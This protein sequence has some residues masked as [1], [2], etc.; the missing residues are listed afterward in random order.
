M[1]SS[2]IQQLPTGLLGLLQLKNL[3][4]N[5]SVLLDDVRP[6]V[7]MLPLWL[8]T[9]ASQDP[10][11]HSSVL[12]TGGGSAR[13]FA[14]NPLLV[15]QDETWFVHRYH[16]GAS[17]DLAAADVLKN[18]CPVA[19]WNSAGPLLWNSLV[20][21]GLDCASDL[22]SSAQPVVG[23]GGF[24]LPPGSELGFTF[25]HATT[26]TSITVFGNAFVTRMPS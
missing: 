14:T 12:N 18:L 15:P 7:D 19:I 17:F 20:R 5:P 13:G 11:G 21:V 9:S 6:I 2:P 4:K 3:G 8:M 1:P 22:A 23:C 25:A 24:W 26:A 16:V 10:N